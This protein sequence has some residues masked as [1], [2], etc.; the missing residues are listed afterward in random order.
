MKWFLVV[1]AL[2]PVGAKAQEEGRVVRI[3]GALVDEVV[4]IDSTGLT[5]ANN[6]H[7][8][9]AMML[10]LEVRVK[11]ESYAKRGLVFGLLGSATIGALLAD[12][13]RSRCNTISYFDPGYSERASWCFRRE[14]GIFSGVTVA[15]TLLGWIVGSQTTRDVWLRVPVGSRRVGIEGSFGFD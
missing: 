1:A 7:F 5:L 2:A 14:L 12:D 4:A 9:Y 11:Q 13:Y 10:S 3:S 6:G 15:G 8:P